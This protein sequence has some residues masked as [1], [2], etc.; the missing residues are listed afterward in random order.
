M[1]LN[2]K[3]IFLN[4]IPYMPKLLVTRNVLEI[5]P[6]PMRGFSSS[7]PEDFDFKDLDKTEHN[8]LTVFKYVIE[9]KRK[10][11]SHAF[12][13][14]TDGENTAFVQSKLFGLQ[15]E[16]SFCVMST[17]GEDD[18]AWMDLTSSAGSRPSS[19]QS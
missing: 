8:G 15:T 17:V 13:I 18:F 4:T 6:K 14:L 7:L 3:R 5:D 19:M 1:S 10:E 11:P 16:G 2:H 9:V 12:A